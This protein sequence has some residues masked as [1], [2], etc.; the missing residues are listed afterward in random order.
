MF[1]R[2]WKLSDLLGLSE[3]L[4]SKQCIEKVGLNLWPAPSLEDDAPEQDNEG[5][6]QQSSGEETV[7][8]VQPNI[9]SFREVKR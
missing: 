8:D 6:Q 3:D 2:L 7:E 4:T 9:L 5:N 1:P